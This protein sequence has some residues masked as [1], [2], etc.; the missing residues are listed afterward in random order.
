[1]P[2]VADPASLTRVV[3]RETL[4]AA[5]PEEGLPAGS[6]SVKT[7]YEPWSFSVAESR[8]PGTASHGVDGSRSGSGATGAGRR[9][10]V[11]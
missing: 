5:T 7:D 11:R 10:A 1:M 3:E 8:L 9:I 2:R 6:G 4:A